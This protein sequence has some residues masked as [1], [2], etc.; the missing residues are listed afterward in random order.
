[1]SSQSVYPIAS[2]IVAVIFCLAIAGYMGFLLFSQYRSQSELQKF[3]L[4]VQLMDSEKHATALGYFFSE[5]ADDIIRLAET[6]ELSLYFENKALGMSMEYGLAASLVD[7]EVAFSTFREKRKLQNKA[8]YTRVLFLDASGR[9]LLEAGKPSDGNKNSPENDVTSYIV[10]KTKVPV[11]FAE[12]RNEDSLLT[13][14]FPYYFKEVY[15]GQILVQM[16]LGVVYNQFVH[17]SGTGDLQLLRVLLF[18]HKYIYSSV[19]SDWLTNPETVPFP[20]RLEDGTPHQLRVPGNN[21]SFKMVNVYTTLVAGTPFSLATCIPDNEQT[22]FTSPMLWIIFTGSIGFIILVGALVIIR[23]TL[24]NQ[25]LRASLNEIKI[26]DK[27][28]AEQNRSLKKLTAAVEQSANSVIIT[29][30]DGVIEYVN[31]HFTQLTGI[32]FEDAVGKGLNVIEPTA[33]SIGEFSN[34]KQAMSDGRQWAGELLSCRKDGTPFWVNI[35]VAPVKNEEGEVISSVAIAQDI[36]ARKDI[37]EQIVRMNRELEQRVR[38]RTSDLEQSNLKLGKAYNDLKTAQSQMLQQEKM[39]SIGQLAA[40]VAHEIN[41]PMGFMLSNLGSMRKYV[42]RL[43]GFIEIQ[44]SAT[45]ALATKTVDAENVLHELKGQRKAMKIDRIGEDIGQ[46]VTESIDGGERVKQIVQNLKSFA[47][48]DEAECK[49]VNL[50]EGLEST[51]NIVWNELKYKATLK[52]EYGEIPAVACNSGQINQVF[53]NLLVNAA[54]AIEQQGEITVRTWCDAAYVYVAIT[55]SGC[56]IPP[57][58]LNRI[59]EPFYTTKEVGNGT[60]L[61]LSISYDIVKKHD[62]EILVE[63]E[64]AKG[65]T[66]TIKLPV[67]PSQGQGCPI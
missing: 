51:I 34:L 65:T 8:I 54:Q 56:G 55:D 16:P 23:I 41:N 44:S 15:S 20:E 52:K 21:G 13:I 49:H 25:V 7:A 33:M 35:T 59:F 1:M 26:R 57:Q 10:K 40:G 6:R 58:S 39:A 64:V 19:Q 17:Q 5:R 37:E 14:S 32:L 31:P 48:L 28:I 2:R 47:R 4:N 3:Y 22:L 27:A 67:S 46:L 61:G 63:S 11:Y 9:K 38:E 12:R 66:F 18:R 42:A 24:R 50:N 62:G 53:L 29:G 45:E 30:T 60:G 36:T 43:L